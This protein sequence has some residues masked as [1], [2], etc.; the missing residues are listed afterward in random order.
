MYK[1]L[2]VSQDWYK[3]LFLD[4]WKSSFISKFLLWCDLQ[5][6]KNVKDEECD[7]CHTVITEILNVLK[8]KI[9]Q[10]ILRYRCVH[11]R[12]KLVG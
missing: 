12:V 5:V 6:Y 7:M 8:D 3:V 4:I 2:E 11:F 10:V 9:N 1:Q